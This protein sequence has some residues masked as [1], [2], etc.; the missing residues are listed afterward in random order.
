LRI[1][2]EAEMYIADDISLCFDAMSGTTLAAPLLCLRQTETKEVECCLISPAS[3]NGQ[4]SSRHTPGIAVLMILPLAPAF[5][6][7]KNNLPLL[8]EMAFQ[9]SQQT[10]VYSFA[11]IYMTA[12][13]GDTALRCSAPEDL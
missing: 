6:V 7:K 9:T 4:A 1:L 3:Y 13:C 2:V 11:P 5:N 12:T 10:K 8:S